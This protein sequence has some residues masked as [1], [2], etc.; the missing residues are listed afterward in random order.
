MANRNG[1]YD[2]GTAF[3]VTTDGQFRV[4]HWFRGDTDGA[5]PLAGLIQALDGHFYGTTTRRGLLDGGTIFR[6]TPDGE[7]TALHAFAGGQDGR[8]QSRR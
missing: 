8:I 1:A 5:F 7:T 6:M 2:A 4:L 3:E